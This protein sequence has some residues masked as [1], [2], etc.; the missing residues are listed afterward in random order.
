MNIMAAAKISEIN[1]P[2]NASVQ[3]GENITLNIAY[4]TT[5]SLS[6]RN[7]TIYQIDGEKVRVR[8]AISGDMSEFCLV[9]KDNQLV[10]VNVLSSTFSVPNSLYHIYIGSNF[11]KYN[12]TNEPINKLPHTS[13]ILRTGIYYF[14]YLIIFFYLKILIF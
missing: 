1:P 2:Y 9:D 4:D 6:A 10:T 7:I 3:L 8:L 14:I 11:V 12:E 13:W 5:V